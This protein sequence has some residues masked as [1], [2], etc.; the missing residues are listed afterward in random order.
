MRKRRFHALRPA[1]IIQELDTLVRF[2]PDWTRHVGQR[3]LHEQG[4]D[5]AV[6]LAVFGQ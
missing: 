6:I 4:L 2:K 1:F 5:E 3:F